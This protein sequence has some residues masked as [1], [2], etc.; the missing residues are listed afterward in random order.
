L[1]PG[2]ARHPRVSDI[3]GADFVIVRARV[4]AQNDVCVRIK[5]DC[6]LATAAGFFRVDLAIPGRI[7]FF[8]L[9]LAA[10]QLA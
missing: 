4:M 1:F 9:F 3:A 8:V 2:N 5:F 7:L 6:D 10:G